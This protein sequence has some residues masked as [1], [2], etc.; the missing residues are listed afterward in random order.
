MDQDLNSRIIATSLCIV[1]LAACGDRTREDNAA[2]VV[3]TNA[4]VYTLDA[5]QPWAE[6]VAVKGNEIV[7]VGDEVGAGGGTF[8]W[9]QQ[10]DVGGTEFD[11]STNNSEAPWGGMY[12]VVQI[13]N[14][15]LES[16]PEVGMGAAT[17]SGV[18]ALANTYK[19][20]AFGNLL[21]IF[22]RIPLDV[23]PTQA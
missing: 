17:L 15:L 5:A 14:V 7:Y 19:A 4:K 23:D 3:F 20:M 21:M 10:V 2:D 16:A 8:Q 12:D 22:E 18:L 1:L 13:A 6:A 11:N 9:I